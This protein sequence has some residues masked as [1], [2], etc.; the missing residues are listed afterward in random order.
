MRASPDVIVVG[1]GAVMIRLVGERDSERRSERRQFGRF[2]A[3]DAVT[4]TPGVERTAAGAEARR[5][6]IAGPAEKS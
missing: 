1:N 3:A 4:T 5:R 2:A 6:S